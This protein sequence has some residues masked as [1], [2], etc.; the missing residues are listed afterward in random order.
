MQLAQEIGHFYKQ[1]EKPA[2]QPANAELLKFIKK[3][4]GEL[5]LDWLAPK[6]PSKN[7]L[8]EWFLQSGC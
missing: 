5:G 7:R 6:E 4:V 8:D 1:D 2:T 3:A